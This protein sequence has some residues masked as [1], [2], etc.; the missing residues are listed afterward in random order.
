MSKL[1][2]R[3]QAERRRSKGLI[4]LTTEIQPQAQPTISL[5]PFGHA[6][7]KAGSATTE[8]KPKD[9]KKLFNRIKKGVADA[10]I[11]YEKATAEH[12]MIVN[13]DDKE[14]QDEEDI[15]ED[16]LKDPEERARDM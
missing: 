1:P 13:I 14:E 2:L 8:L 5:Q 3:P 11:A 10:E 4:D 12:R 9:E 6:A 15:L 16:A 7:E